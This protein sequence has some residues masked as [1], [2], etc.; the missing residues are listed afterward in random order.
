MFYVVYLGHAFLNSIIV[1]CYNVNKLT[2]L[3]TS[4]SAERSHCAKVQRRGI[5]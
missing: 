3:L 4:M 5:S 2:Y 1:I